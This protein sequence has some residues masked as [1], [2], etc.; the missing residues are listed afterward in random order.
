MDIITYTTK[1]I[2]ILVGMMNWLLESTRAHGRLRGK[3]GVK[4]NLE[5]YEIVEN[6]SPFRLIVK[7]KSHFICESLYKDLETF[8]RSS[9]Y[10]FR[11]KRPRAREKHQEPILETSVPRKKKCMSKIHEA[12]CYYQTS[13][14]IT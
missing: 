12:T 3:K 8:S 10:I 14:N 13:N 5:F 11:R 7:V 4:I 6:R 9:L 2:G 1:R